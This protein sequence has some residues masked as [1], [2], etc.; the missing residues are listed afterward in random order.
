MLRSGDI[1]RGVFGVFLCLLNMQLQAEEFRVDPSLYVSVRY[2]DNLRLLETNKE[3]IAGVTATPKLKMKMDAEAWDFNI[4]GSVRST[5]YPSN[6]S[7]DNNSVFFVANSIYKTELSQYQLNIRN[8]DTASLNRNVKTILSDAGKEDEQWNRK[9][10]TIDINW[11]R[12]LSEDTEMNIDLGR[13]VVSY[14]G[15]VPSGFSGYSTNNAALSYGWEFSERSRLDATAS[16]LQF[17]NEI[18]T[19]EYDQ[20]VYQLSYG[21]SLT[22]AYG[23][24]LSAGKR[25]L[26]SVFYN[27]LIGCDLFNLLDG[28]C[29]SPVLGDI[30]TKNDGNVISASLNT[31][32]EVSQYGIDLSRTVIPSSVSGAQQQDQIKFNYQYSINS[33]L[34]AILNTNSIKTLT[35]EGVNNNRD[36]KRRI[37]DLSLKYK[38]ARDISLSFN[39]QYISSLY[40]SDGIDRVSNSVS[41]NLYTVWPR[42]M[43]TY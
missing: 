5:R 22:Q 1:R 31:S 40:I 38:V 28:S 26:K 14:R 15:T 32:S 27:Q 4:D 43:S 23:F 9:T 19:F 34:A 24:R 35:I 33:R 21:Y 25:V 7:L 42:L 16:L 29:L 37:L 3:S 17:S 6:G 11:Q 10:R 2:D 20:T 18:N 36:I 39:Y 12:Q 8:D 41:I 13:T 30:E